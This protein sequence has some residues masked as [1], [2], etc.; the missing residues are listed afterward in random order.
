VR[1]TSVLTA[2]VV[3]LSLSL[4]P[5]A[6]APVFQRG[7]DVFTTPADGRTFYDFAKTP[8][9]AGFF[10]ADSQ[11]FT[12]RVAFKGLPL[13][14]GAPGQLWGGDTVVERLDDGIF[15]AKGRATTRIQFRALSLVSIAPIQTSC[16]AFHVYVSLAGPQRMTVMSIHRTKKAGGSFVA[17]LAVDVRMTFIPVDAAKSKS[18]RKLELAQG[19]TFLPRPVSWSFPTGATNKSRSVVVDTNGDLTPDTQLS[20]IA[21]F[22]LGTGKPCCEICHAD[23]SCWHCSYPAG[24]SGQCP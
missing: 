17:P 23:G 11:P 19:V 12:G 1:K 22:A 15:N 18:A 24:C 16:G 5:A 7:L 10:C 6:A 8:I 21:D 9:P 20:F 14:T 3:S 4:S 2:L 13:V